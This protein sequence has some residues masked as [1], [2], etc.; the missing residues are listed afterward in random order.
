MAYL[1]MD[2]NAAAEYKDYF[3]LG[4]MVSST[5]N[6]IGVSTIRKQI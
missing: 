3:V 5:L 1:K 6:G 4:E 2:R